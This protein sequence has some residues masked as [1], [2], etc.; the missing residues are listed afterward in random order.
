MVNKLT[1][2]KIYTLLIN[3]DFQN[4]QNGLEIRY[5][6]KHWYINNECNI[7]DKWKLFINDYK[8]FFRKIEY[9]FTDYSFIGSLIVGFS[10]WLWALLLDY[11][12][13]LCKW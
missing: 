8:K 7:T 10:W 2:S 5:L 12:I 9:F 11:L 4:T 3:N 1:Y 13:K 6:Q